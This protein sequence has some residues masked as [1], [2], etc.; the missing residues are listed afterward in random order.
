MLRQ[1]FSQN[2]FMSSSPSSTSVGFFIPSASCFSSTA[3]SSSPHSISTAL[4]IS[5][6]I[7]GID[8]PAKMAQLAK[9]LL[10]E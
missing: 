7:G 5:H 4:A 6:G 10:Q 9:S 2:P 3:E 1:G 8:I